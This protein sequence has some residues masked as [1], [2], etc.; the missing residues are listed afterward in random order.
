[1][2]SGRLDLK[3]LLELNTL[4]CWVSRS[5]NSV[6]KCC[7]YEEEELFHRYDL[8]VGSYVDNSRVF[9]KFVDDIF[10]RDSITNNRSFVCR[11]C[12]FVFSICFLPDLQNK[13]TIKILV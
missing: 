12:L 4:H 9:D 6:I 8:P 7:V 13:H 1:M 10:N 3:H 11:I 2:L 5:G